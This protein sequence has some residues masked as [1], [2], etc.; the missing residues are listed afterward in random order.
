MASSS[1]NRSSN[2]YHNTH[3]H[4]HHP[5]MMHKGGT[6]N[7][8]GAYPQQQQTTTLPGINQQSLQGHASQDRQLIESNKR[9]PS[10]F[11]EFQRS[12]QGSAI[13]SP[14]GNYAG[15]VGMS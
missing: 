4:N 8:N 9:R 5:H 1:M 12:A 11:N 14:A 2:F 6:G 13:N 7:L 10:S 3:S 15:I